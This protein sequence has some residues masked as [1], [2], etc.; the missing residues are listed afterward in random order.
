[1]KEVTRMKNIMLEKQK[2][3]IFLSWEGVEKAPS[4]KTKKTMLLVL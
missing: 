3:K 4:T 1:M 2:Q